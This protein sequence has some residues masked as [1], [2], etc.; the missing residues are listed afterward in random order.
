MSTVIT[1]ELKR[2]IVEEV[3]PGVPAA[4]GTKPLVLRCPLQPLGCVHN[5]GDRSPSFSLNPG[6]GSWRCKRSGRTGGTWK[7]LVVEL[8]GEGRW[9]ELTGGNRASAGRLEDRWERLDPEERWTRDYGIRADLSA[10]YLRRGKWTPQEDTSESVVGL[11]SEGKLRGI[12]WRKPERDGYLWRS[13][14]VKGQDV[15]YVWTSGSHPKGFLFL[16]DVAAAKTP[17]VRVLVCA[18]EKDALVAASHLDPAAWAPVTGVDGEATPPSK[19]LRELCQGRR[20]VI[21]YDPDQAGRGGAWLVATALR[22]AAEEV[23]AAVLPEGEAGPDEPKWDVAALVRYRGAASLAQVLEQ[24]IPVPPSWKPEH[25]KE[26]PA[27]APEASGEAQEEG[28]RIRDVLEA[29]RVERGVIVEARRDKEGNERLEL[30][31][32]GTIRIACEEVIR[33]EDPKAVAGWAEE[34]NLTYEVEVGGAKFTRTAEGGKSAF[35]KLLDQDLAGA[36]RCQYP[37]QRVALHQWIAQRG[38]GVRKEVTHALGH[39]ASLGGWVS[40]PAIRVAEGRVESTPYLLGAP[41]IVQDM[42]RYRL[43][44]LDRQ[45]LRRVSAWLV[46]DLVRCDHADR[47]YSLPVLATLVAAPLWPYVRPLASWQRYALFVHGTSGTGKTHFLRSMLCMWGSFLDTEDLTTWASS[48]T[49]LE[50]LLHQAV[51]APVFVADYK[52]SNMTAEKRREALTL[53]QM[54]ADRTSKGRGGTTGG[55]LRRRPPRCQ[56]V[57]DGEDLPEGQQATLGRLLL[58]KVEPHAPTDRCATTE[59]L[60]PAMLG[61]LPGVTAAW[62][63]WVQREHARLAHHL[64]HVRDTLDQDLAEAPRTTNRSR[65]VRNYAVQLAALGAFARWLEDEVGVTGACRELLDRGAEVHRELALAQLGRVGEEAAAQLFLD[66]LRQLLESGVAYLRPK[67]QGEPK[68][69]NPWGSSSS[70]GPGSTCV[71]TYDVND[72]VLLW[73]DMAIGLVQQQHTKG[74]GDRIEFTKGA[75]AEQLEQQGVIERGER[76][77]VN[78]A[79]SR[80][81]VTTVEKLGGERPRQLW[82]QDSET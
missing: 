28:P 14:Q 51:A 36:D 81:W 80:V 55:A 24:A 64:V 79:R 74:G 18:G 65:I 82:D 4:L 47:A 15:K 41:G 77:Y 25:V 70:P 61:L 31:F 44:E 73:P 37:T 63:A 66:T 6:G 59:R 9:R 20:V 53:I 38:A 76:G 56:L 1:D 34:R 35:L 10:R 78:G 32:K 2:R 57:I 27:I 3:W 46:S 62:I 26:A 60:D 42:N 22:G 52:R 48:A 12:K 54:Y 30:R 50:D 43:L 8:F 11:W 13:G 17:D 58:L 39:H 40:P 72:Q 69:V 33:R 21:A 19:A 68:K 45:E 75:I 67:G 16:G 7:S 71:G 29:W 5:N 23:L 49:H